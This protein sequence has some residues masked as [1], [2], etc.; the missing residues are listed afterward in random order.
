[1]AFF[2]ESMAGSLN[3]PNAFSNPDSIGKDDKILTVTPAMVPITEK[4]TA[5]TKLPRTFSNPDS[6]GKDVQLISFELSDSCNRNT[7]RNP[8][9]GYKNRMSKNVSFASKGQNA[10]L[11]QGHQV[12]S[13]YKS[14]QQNEFVIKQPNTYD[15]KCSTFK[16]PE[17]LGNF[18]IDSDGNFVQNTLPFKFIDGKYL[19]AD[20]EMNVDIDLTKDVSDSHGAHNAVKDEDLESL[21]QWVTHNK[22]QF[23]EEDKE[24]LTASIISTHNSLS[25][26]MKIPYTPKNEWILSATMYKGTVYLLNAKQSGKT[27]P[28]QNLGQKFEDYI[29]GDAIQEEASS[30]A[31]CV[32]RT[33]LDD[34]ELLYAPDVDCADPEKFQESFEDLSNFIN[35]ETCK[36]L[37]GQKANTYY[38][39]HKTRDIW[40]ESKLSGIPRTVV[41]FKTEE[42]KVNS[43]RLLDVNELPKIGIN[44]WKPNVCLKF[45]S[46]YLSYIKKET[47]KH[48]NQ[49]LEFTKHSRGSITWKI[50]KNSEVLPQW[51]KDEIFGTHDTG[52]DDKEVK[53]EEEIVNQDNPD[54]T[55][56][57]DGDNDD[58]EEVHS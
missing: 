30:S 40:C 47:S 57:G 13:P 26:I 29:T 37:S 8:A 10:L 7:Y 39:K 55:V 58:A 21:L 18:F 1:M 33:Q 23:L 42:G 15:Q 44:S 36:E 52:K 51:Y 17:V 6:I 12:A 43:I 25:E 9:K 48:P 45:L 38:K 46:T 4:M 20:G 3:V 56:D 22:T 31:H 19:T 28:A 16:E 24:R 49:V 53:R 2:G 50:A 27:D 5:S 32:L 54:K 11:S 34:L 41:G 35:I 14:K